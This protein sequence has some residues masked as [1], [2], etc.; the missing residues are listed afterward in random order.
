MYNDRAVIG[1]SVDTS[2]ETAAA[3]QAAAEAIACFTAATRVPSG[4]IKNIVSGLNIGASVPKHYIKLFSR[5]TKWLAMGHTIKFLQKEDIDRQK[6][7]QI[8]P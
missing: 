3:S 7:M 4:T 2:N 1:H 6:P 5:L 8:L